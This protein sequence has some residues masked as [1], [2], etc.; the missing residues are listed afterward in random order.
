MD[1]LLQFDLAW[2]VPTGAA[3]LRPVMVILTSTPYYQIA[4]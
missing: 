2:I 3:L 4:A 1:Q